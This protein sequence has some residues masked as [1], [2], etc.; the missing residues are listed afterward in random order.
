MALTDVS[1]ASALHRAHLPGGLFVDLGPR[2]L[3]AYYRGFLRSPASIGLIA[4]RN[5]RRIGFLVGTIDQTA[6]SQHLAHS[7]IVR[8][9]IV[10]ALALLVRPALVRR[11]IRTRMGRYATGIA[12]ARARTPDAARRHDGH[13][14]A[15]HGYK[16]RIGVLTAVAVD[17]AA[18]RSG[19]GRDLVNAFVGVA[20]L[21][22][23]DEL[24]LYARRDNAATSRFYPGL[25][26]KPG[27]E[28]T[29]ADGQVWLS[30]TLEL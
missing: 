21:C 27:E 4:E 6:H 10:G 29:D 5:G 13:V 20:D 1:F 23:T 18:Q 11:F 9:V 28:H 26:W 12:R 3:R 17:S 24:R 22:Q 15:S 30:Y 16:K 19:V 25:G 2:F 8:M 14:D 7:G